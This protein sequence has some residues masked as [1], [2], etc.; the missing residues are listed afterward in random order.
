MHGPH[1]GLFYGGSIAQL[2]TICSIV[3]FVLPCALAASWALRSLGWLRVTTAEEKKGAD[4][5]THGEKAYE[6]GSH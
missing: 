3:G 4:K 5:A 6:K 2:L 1:I